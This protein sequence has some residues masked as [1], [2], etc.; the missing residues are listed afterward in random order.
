MPVDV[1]VKERLDK[2]ADQV[3]EA[4]E[5]ALAES[6]KGV[7]MSEKTKAEVDDMLTKHNELMLQLAEDAKKGVSRIE[8]LEQKLNRRGGSEDQAEKSLGQRFIEDEGYKSFTQQKGKGKYG[9]NVKAV[10]TITSATTGTGAGGANVRNDRIVSPFLTP[11]QRRMTVRDLIA[12]GRTDSNAI[13]YVQETGFQNMAA[14]QGAEG[15]AKAQS[16]IAFSLQNSSVVTIAHYVKASKQILADA[17]MMESY[18]DG[19]LKYGLEYAEELQLL[20]GSGTG[21]NLNGIYTQATAYSAPVGGIVGTANILD[22]IR[23]AML[24]AMLAEYPADGTILNPIQWSAMETLKD[25]QGRYIIGDPKGVASPTLWGLPV[26]A[27]QAMTTDKFLVGSFGMGAQV[28]DREDAAV[29]VSTEDQDNFVKNLVTILAEERLALAVYRPEAFI[30][31]DLGL[32][33]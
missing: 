23:L 21:G 32:V 15:T 19:R 7:E 12:K 27:T 30:K 26:V 10:T 22:I 24:Q 6:K 4:G 5:K 20:M 25:T 11:G 14:V 13:E 31:G 33:A 2:I 16:D 3:K 28:F 8:E 9:M 17:P 1:E 29:L 18:I